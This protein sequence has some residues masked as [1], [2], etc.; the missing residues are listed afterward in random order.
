MLQQ[1]HVPSDLFSRP[2][3]GY[4][5]ERAHRPVYHHRQNWTMN[6]KQDRR[7]FEL[8]IPLRKQKEPTPHLS[9]PVAQIALYHIGGFSKVFFSKSRRYQSVRTAFLLCF[10]ALHLHFHPSPIYHDAFT[11]RPRSCYQAAELCECLSNSVSCSPKRS[12]T[13]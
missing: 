6:Y 9:W 5:Q 7:P 8:S 3:L 13:P 2:K 1:N 11:F 12:S 10:L 4:L